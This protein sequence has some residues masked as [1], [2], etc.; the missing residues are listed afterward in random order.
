MNHPSRPLLSPNPLSD[1]VVDG[2]NCLPNTTCGV[3]EG[4]SIPCRETQARLLTQNFVLLGLVLIL[5][6]LFNS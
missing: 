3:G 6:I 2:R 1:V 4:I 5:F